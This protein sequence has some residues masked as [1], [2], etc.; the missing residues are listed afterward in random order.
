MLAG[1]FPSQKMSEG[2]IAFS[3]FVSLCACRMQDVQC[4]LG[5]AASGIPKFI[6]ATQTLCHFLNPLDMLHNFK[7]CYSVKNANVCLF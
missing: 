6:A 7:S 4:Q 1:S 3:V 5:L 2:G